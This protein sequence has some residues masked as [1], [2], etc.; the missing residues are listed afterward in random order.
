MRKAHSTS[1]IVWAVGAC[2][3]QPGFLA[4]TLYCLICGTETAPCLALELQGHHSKNHD[5]GGAAAGVP[6]GSR[7][8]VVD[9]GHRAADMASELHSCCFGSTTDGGAAPIQHDRAPAPVGHNISHDKPRFDRPV[10]GVELLGARHRTRKFVFNPG[11]GGDE[12]REEEA[13]ADQ[14]SITGR[15]TLNIV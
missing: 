15:L 9:K 4:C 6:K 7:D 8:A 2:T 1:R 14:Q 13:T 5:G 11:Q 3:Q 10:A 12:Q